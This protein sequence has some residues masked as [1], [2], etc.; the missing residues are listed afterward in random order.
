MMNTKKTS[1]IFASALMFS[2][3][4]AFAE[5]DAAVAEK[6]TSLLQKLDS[7]NQA[8]LGLQHE[9]VDGRTGLSG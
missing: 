8:V 5:G 4:A 6:Q 7:L 3:V 1:I 9:P 2:A